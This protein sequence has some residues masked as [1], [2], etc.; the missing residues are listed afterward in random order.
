MEYIFSC[1]MLVITI[2]IIGGFSKR[3][4]PG[5]GWRHFLMGEDE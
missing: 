2:L 3:S 4:F 1:L 5:E